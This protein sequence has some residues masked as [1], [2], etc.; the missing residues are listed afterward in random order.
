M[1]QGRSQPLARKSIPIWAGTTCAPHANPN[2]RCQSPPGHAPAPRPLGAAPAPGDHSHPRPARGTAGI[3]TR[4]WDTSCSP[5]CPPHSVGQTTSLGVSAPLLQSPPQPGVWASPRAARSTASTAHS[6][7][8]VSHV[9]FP[10]WQLSEVTVSE[11]QLSFK[12][13]KARSL[14]CSPQSEATKQDLG[15]SVGSPRNILIFM[16]IV[17]NL[18]ISTQDSWMHLLQE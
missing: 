11:S 1:L 17:Q 2:L 4:G 18:K 12:R 7:G 16:S 15:C 3:S 8:P 14:H 9:V 10:Q 5:S 6:S 13:N